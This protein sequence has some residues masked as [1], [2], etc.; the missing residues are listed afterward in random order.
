MDLVPCFKPVF[1][2]DVACICLTAFQNHSLSE[3]A[4]LHQRWPGVTDEPLMVVWKQVEETP[5]D[6]KYSCHHITVLN[7]INM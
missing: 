3:L 2:V 4:K 6:I 5:G 7:V 1:N